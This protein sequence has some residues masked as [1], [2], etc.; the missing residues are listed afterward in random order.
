[1]AAP[2]DA[3]EV[4]YVGRL[5][6]G[7]LFDTSIESE[8]K[9]SGLY[10]TGRT[11]QP[12]AFTIGDKS[13]LPEFEKAIIGMSVG[14]K[15]TITIEAK[16]AYGEA[17]IERS[18]PV[19]AFQDTIDQEVPKSAFS[20][21]ISQSVDS[22][23]LGITPEELTK[24]KVGQMITIQGMQVRYVGNS[25]SLITIEIPNTSNPFMGKKI[26][27]GA[28]AELE[29]NTITIKAVTSTGVILHVDN[30][31]NPFYGKKLTLGL[32]GKM[33]D[34]SEIEIK[35]IDPENITILTQNTHPLAG[36]RL[37]FDLTLVKINTT[38]K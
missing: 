24:Y 20:D 1:M 3:V 33:A 5:D 23:V 32:K 17:T 26:E 14:G 25:G 8:A 37:T 2:G 9:T 30:K 34:G 18:V 38:V 7:K 4:D 21:S 13:L 12:L 31:S 10:Q 6:D 11:Y 22:S 36:K 29:G 27:V 35:N 15:K 16:D 28:K 19:K